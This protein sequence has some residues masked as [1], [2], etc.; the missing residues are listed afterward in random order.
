MH[1]AFKNIYLVS[2]ANIRRVI[3]AIVPP[4][5]IE[6]VVQETYVRLCQAKNVEN[7]IAKKSFMYTTAKNIALD[8]HK[9][10][11]LKNIDDSADWQDFEQLL[12]HQTKN[13]MLE[14]TITNDEFAYYCEAIRQLPI[15]CKKVFV[16]KKIY[17]YSQKEIARQMNISESTVEKHLSQGTKRCMLMMQ[18]IDVKETNTVQQHKGKVGSLN[19]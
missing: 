17:G 5:E 2:R 9:Q 10:A 8:Y 4:Q 7:I 15:Q 18:K 3:A 1:N 14:I 11:R 19:E 12:G 6:D 16:L 13:D